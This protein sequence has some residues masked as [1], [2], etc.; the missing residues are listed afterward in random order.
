MRLQ[1]QLFMD[2]IVN[3]QTIAGARLEAPIG[4]IATHVITKVKISADDLAYA[5]LEDD[6]IRKQSAEGG[7][8]LDFHRSDEGLLVTAPTDALRRYVSAHTEDAFSDFE[9]LKR[10]GK[11]PTQP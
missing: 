1:G 7:V 9:H 6:A 4:V 10:K 2:L 8:P 3:D 11:T 5:T